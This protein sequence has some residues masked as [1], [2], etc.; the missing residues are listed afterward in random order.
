MQRT[1]LDTKN[2]VKDEA[3]FEIDLH[4]DAL[5]NVG[6]HNRPLT[7]KSLVTY[8]R[9]YTEKYHYQNGPK[10]YT[11][12]LYYHLGSLRKQK[13]KLIKLSTVIFDRRRTSHHFP[14][15]ERHWTESLSESGCSWLCLLIFFMQ[16]AICACGPTTG[17]TQSTVV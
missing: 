5:Y 6:L 9:D 1:V 15:I 17:N 7:G 8:S 11:Q 13:R 10:Q 12:S 4:V 2:I 3:T 14:L 16:D